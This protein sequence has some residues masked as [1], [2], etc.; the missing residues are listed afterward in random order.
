MKILA[1]FNTPGMTSD[2]YD[3]CLREL[4]NAGLNNPDGRVLHVAGVKDDGWHV[5]DVWESEEQFA[6]FGEAL[7]PILASIGAPI[8]EP[9]IIPFYNSIGG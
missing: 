4:D 1:V 9:E 8:V 7:M 3:Q 5:T 2:Q 6:K